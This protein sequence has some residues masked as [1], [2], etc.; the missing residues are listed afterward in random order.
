MKPDETRRKFHPR[1]GFQVFQ[2]HGH[3]QPAGTLVQ[4]AGGC[5]AANMTAAANMWNIYQGFQQ[6]CGTFTQGF[7]G[8]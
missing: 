4:A 3:H 6:R 2:T 5:L 8:N 1:L 7:S